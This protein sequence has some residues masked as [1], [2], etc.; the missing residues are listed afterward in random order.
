MAS[1]EK[2]ISI[3]KDKNLVVRILTG[4][5]I[6]AVLGFIARGS[7]A[8]FIAALAGGVGTLG[9]LFV[10][11]LKAVAPVLVFILIAASFITKNFTNTKGLKLV[12][13]LYLSSTLLASF[14]GVLASFM[15]PTPL[16]LDTTSA[17]NATAPTSLVEV[18]G[19]LLFKMVDNPINALA[20]GNYVG[21]LTWAIGF[22]LALR[23]ASGATKDIFGD[24]ADG[25]T[26]I[27]QFIIQLA[28]FGIMGLV[29]NS[30]IEAGGEALLGYLRLIVVLVGAMAFVA[31]VTNPLIAGIA[32]KKNPYPLLFTCLKESG[33]YAFFTRSSA[34]N[35]PVNLNLCRKLELD[36][37]LYPISIPLGATINMAGAAVVIAIL[38]LAAVYTL[39]IE[40]SF[41][42]ALLLCFVSALGAT[43]A[44]GVPGGSLMLI[45]LATSLFNI[46]NEIAMQ[47]IAVGFIIGVIQD[48]VETAINSSTDVLYTAVASMVTNNK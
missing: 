41:G 27:V 20:T 38:S 45:P 17:V 28:P 8:A 42:T 30:V 1:F 7:D 26:K 21:I 19:G 33:L 3:Y 44:G 12:I 46:P 36:E 16:V 13:V 32:L 37:E 2:L 10:G 4:V 6:G 39:G 5:F 25:I 18:L 35:I 22:G 11:A 15:F 9:S 29:T 23:F 34:A 47:V 14:V 24:L 43:G 48:S 40:V 31:L